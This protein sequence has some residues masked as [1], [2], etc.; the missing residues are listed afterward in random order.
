MASRRFFRPRRFSRRGL[1]RTRWT[2]EAVTAE[3]STAA[4]NITISDIVT[5]A[6]YEQSSTLEQGAATLLRV[7]GDVSFRTATSGAI[8]A[9]TVLALDEDEG[10]SVGGAN[11]PLTLNGDLRNGEILWRKSGLMVAAWPIYIEFDIRAKRR[12][13]QTRVTIAV[14]ALVQTVIWQYSARALIKGG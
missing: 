3:Q 8:F 10:F 5:P 1:S 9:V 7:R 2:G 4:N 11:D 13:Q 6:D 14:K 12:L